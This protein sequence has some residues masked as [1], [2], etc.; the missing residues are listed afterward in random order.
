MTLE[1]AQEIFKA[2]GECYNHMID[3]N[4]TCHLD[5]DSC[6]LTY[7][8]GHLGELREAC[9]MVVGILEGIK[10]MD[11]DAIYGGCTR[12]VKRR[13]NEDCDRCIYKME[14]DDDE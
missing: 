10:Y 13:N 3:P 5:C 1:R 4:L 11:T 12:T 6:D 7:Q 14:A 8:K 2:L 9:Y